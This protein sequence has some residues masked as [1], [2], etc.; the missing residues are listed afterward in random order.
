MLALWLVVVIATLDLGLASLQF[1][2]LSEAARRIARQ[3]I[4]HGSTASPE[5]VP[6]GPAKYTGN[7]ADGSSIATAARGALPTMKPE[8]VQ[9]E[10]E[11]LDGHNN[12]E[13]RVH[14]RISYAHHTF[15]PFA[16]SNTALSLH[17]DSVMRIVH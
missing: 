13:G 2:M 5:A 16:P 11:W 10:L 14:V 9:I 6:W 1:N 15:I 7:A 12:P 8:S 3:A 17:G 4:V